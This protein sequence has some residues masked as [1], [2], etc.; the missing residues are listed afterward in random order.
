MHMQPEILSFIG[1]FA[2]INNLL[3]NKK[4]VYNNKDYINS[5]TSQRK[6]I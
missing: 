3:K 5:I 2:L 1:S 4:N 6:Q